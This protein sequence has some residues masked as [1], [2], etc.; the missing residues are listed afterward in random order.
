MSS[1]GLIQRGYRITG[2]VQGVFYRA[3]TQSTATELG[4]QGAVRN[5]MDGSVEAHVLGE[6]SVV[7]VFEDRLW[8][9]PEAARVTGVEAVE[10]SDQLP[11]GPF[12]ILPTI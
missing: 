12:Q 5:R 11:T 10:S 3:W 9:G 8:D 4:L 7:S 6:P 2:K 1:V